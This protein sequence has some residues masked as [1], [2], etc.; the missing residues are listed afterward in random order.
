MALPVPLVGNGR[1]GKRRESR[2]KVCI[3]L[4]GESYLSCAYLTLDAIVEDIKNPVEFEKKKGTMLGRLL[5]RSREDEVGGPSQEMGDGT[6]MDKKDTSIIYH[7][8]E[9]ERV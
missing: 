1:K 9:L 5:G 2:K 4:K 7:A 3:F 8:K 6:N